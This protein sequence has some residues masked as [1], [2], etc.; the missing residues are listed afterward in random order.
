MK[1]WLRKSVISFLPLWGVTGSEIP[2]ATTKGVP[3]DYHRDPR[4]SIK[5]YM[6]SD[7]MI[8]VGMLVG[9]D[10]SKGGT[11]IQQNYTPEQCVQIVASIL[12]IPTMEHYVQ[13]LLNAISQGQKD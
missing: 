6:D 13:P 9:N 5:E 7:G 2:I 8:S 4:L 1:G 3:D 10:H 11:W 12:S